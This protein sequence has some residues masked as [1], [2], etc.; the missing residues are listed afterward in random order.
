MTLPSGTVTFLFT[1]IEGSTLLWQ[2]F[3]AEM[4]TALAKHDAILKE[5]I[6]SNRGHIIKTTGDGVHAVFVTVIEAINAALSVQHD[7]QLLSDNLEI[8][9]RMGLHT[10]E[11]ERRGD[12]YYGQTLN[13]AARIMSAGHGGQILISSVT[14]ELAREHLPEN[15]NLLDLGEHRL[16]NLSKPEHLYQV[17]APGL[18]TE[19][20]A[21]HSLNLHPNNLSV[22]LTSF[23]GREREL[24]E[25]KQ[26]LEGARLLTLIGPG[27]TGKTRLS[28]QL[29]N[30][31]LV[32]FRDGV[33][34]IEL[35]PI[36]E[37]SLVLQAVAAVFGVREQ[38]GMPLD[39]LVLNYLRDKDLLLILD[40][41]E[42]L[43]ETCAQ[44]ADQYLHHCPNLKILASSREAL[45]INGETVYR[46]PSLVVPAQSKDSP[47]A[48]MG[49]ES[50]QLFVDRASAASPAFNLTEKNAA[51]VAQI[52]YRLDG[53]P[54][55]IELAAA[56]ARVFSPEQIA[57][58]LDDRFRLLTGGSRTALPR[59]QTLRALIDWSYDM[60]SGDEQTLLR[61][62]S[63]FAGGWS[64]E[65]VES[66]YSD[67]DVLDLLTQLV[68]KSLVVMEQ[69]DDTR[70]RLLETIRQYARD[71]LLESGEG[72]EVRNKHLHYFLELAET[73]EPN[74]E[75]FGYLQWATKLN[76]EYDNLRAAL[77]WGLAKDI[78]A[79]LRFVGALPFFWM[80][81]GYSAEGNRWALEV[82]EKAKL[83]AVREI[84]MTNE[85]LNVRARA[86]LALSRMAT[87]LG[88]N[89]TTRSTAI[90]SIA[91]AQKSGNQQ[92]LSYALA[93]LASGKANLGEVAEAYALAQEALAIAREQGNSPAF[94]YSLVM[95][96]Q[97]TA[98][99]KQDPEGALAY[100]EKAI[101]VSEA[102]GNRWGR[103]M[104]IFG[105]GF[106]AKT[107]GDYDQARSRFRT[108]LPVFLEFGDK[109]RINM[110]RS[111]LAHIE[112]EQ[113]QFNQAMP[114]YRETILEWQRLGHRAAIANQLEC[115]AFIA[116]AQEQPERA[117]KLF[118][119]AESLREKINIAM[120][121]Q[122]RSEYDPEIADL[123]ANTDEKVF[124]SH[125]A[126][127]RSL[128]MER[129]VEFALE[130]NYG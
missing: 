63:V 1:D 16:K 34:L 93:Q 85:Q 48:L 5:R 51:S 121:P 76:A 46:V 44:L 10:G 124:A 96:G 123:R 99:F 126:E 64:F 77:E 24:A 68:N 35:A 29:A 2:K 17:K 12:D 101:A 47:E 39:S 67:L 19:F 97:L 3:P 115:F 11:A 43:V 79:A 52:C 50:I 65:A 75:R 86:Y 6:E 31:L 100:G 40:N 53:I 95:M 78:E 111:E 42:H 36:T 117:A 56:R 90:E 55:A 54:L 130:E 70:Y 120:T 14:A 116:K 20:P 82:L 38:P 66:I 13:R 4:N 81:Q 106:F 125:W 122:E 22:Q 114:K 45:G 129:A 8:K 80:T 61:R 128:T 28:L 108:C 21:L 119:A 69:G 127:G 59:Q 15:T 57:S 84:D 30:D 88:D 98:I 102:G 113:G 62:L 104:T 73:A 72:E 58:R 110:I 23:I 103:A 105:L 27:G 112:R 109:H 9:V 7:L 60:L 91:L 71:K 89:E 41:C 32:S 92:T 37:A 87:D 94:G 49:Y 107:T 33:W 83:R 25:A 74:L 26:K 118:G 18:Q